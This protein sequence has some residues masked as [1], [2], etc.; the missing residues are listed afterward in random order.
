MAELC[1]SYGEY[2]VK[3]FR[4]RRGRLLE[5]GQE[6]ATGIYVVCTVKCAS[7]LRA[8]LIKGIA[9]THYDESCRVIYE[10]HLEP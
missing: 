4:L 8:T 7:P 3:R 6:S 2:E 5:P 1:A 10:G 9:E